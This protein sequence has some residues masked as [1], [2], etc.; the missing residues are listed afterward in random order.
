MTYEEGYS[1]L[2]G[3]VDEHFAKLVSLMRAEEDPGM[4]GKF[5][6][7]LGDST[8]KEVIAILESEL[9][10]PHRDVRFWAHSQLEYSDYSEANEIAKKYKEENPSEDWY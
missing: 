5:V 3:N 7:I 10:S 4:R 6:E 1:W 9:A 2:L 8:K